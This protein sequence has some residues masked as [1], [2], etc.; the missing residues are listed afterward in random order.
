MYAK[1]SNIPII[2][3]I[4]LGLAFLGL[5]IFTPQT[6]NDKLLDIFT[7]CLL[8]SFMID[9]KG[10]AENKIIVN[11]F[12]NKGISYSDLEKIVLS[13]KGEE[14]RM[15]YFRNGRRGSCLVFKVP[16]DQL[17]TFLADKVAKDLEIDIIIE[18]NE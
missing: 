15:N 12:D 14:I 6:L 7:S 5:G 18:E 1:R 4:V 11:S 8:F 2:I 9:S 10:L 3:G 16:L 13:I 17:L